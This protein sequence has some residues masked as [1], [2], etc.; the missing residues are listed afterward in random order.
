[1][2]CGTGH[3]VCEPNTKTKKAAVRY[4]SELGPFGRPGLV[5]GVHVT[6][7]PTAAGQGLV[8]WRIAPS[9]WTAWVVARMLSIPLRG[10][11]PCQHSVGRSERPA[12]SRSTW[13]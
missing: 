1:M 5:T 8:L 10:R 9:Y 7:M 13:G 6:E 2:R 3:C 4:L 12:S 11:P